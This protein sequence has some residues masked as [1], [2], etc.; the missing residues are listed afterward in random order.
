MPFCIH[1]SDAKF[2]WLGVI[3]IFTLFHVEPSL[4]FIPLHVEPS[5]EYPITFV[6]E[7]VATQRVPFHVTPFPD[8]VKQLDVAAVQL[9]PFVE[10]TIVFPPEPIATH[11]SPFHATPFP[12]V[13]KMGGTGLRGFR[14]GELYNNVIADG[15]RA[16]V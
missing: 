3:Y 2:V 10:Y 16:T 5:L 13:V 9:I 12:E 15:G 7:P 11:R 6:P 4:E 8:D 1:V 14:E